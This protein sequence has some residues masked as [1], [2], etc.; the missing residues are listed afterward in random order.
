MKFTIT[1][2]KKKELFNSIFHLFKNSSSQ[3]NLTFNTDYL[4]I[5]GMDKS[6][7]CLF[8]L[9]LY[10]EWFDLYE[11]DKKYDICFDTSIFYSMISIKNDEQSLVIK[12]EKDDTLEIELIN[13]EKLGDYNK[14][15]TLNL[16]EYEYEEMKI[17]TTEYDAE[18]TLPSKKITDV[19][20]QLSN[21][22]DDI[23]I[24]C[25]EEKVE[26]KTKGTTSDMRVK[27][28]IDDMISYSVVE[29]EIVNLNY[30]L[31]YISKMCI[32]NKLSANIDFSISNQCPMKI[33]YDLGN[34]S[35]LI[36][37]IAP[38]IADD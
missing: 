6:H 31:Q 30:S 34:K 5:Q 29:G 15:F 36:F 23:N 11:V 12:L 16:I 25:S 28:A 7:I 24:S 22:G 10:D 20:S 19:F 18:F 33:N 1:D 2:K 32:T 21:F 27:I 37:Y 35:S 38:K 9:N 26:F 14:Y 17:P 3:I 13:N 8:D 4:H